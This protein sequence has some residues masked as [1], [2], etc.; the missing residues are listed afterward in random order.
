[1]TATAGVTYTYDGDGKRVKKSSGKLY[2]YGMGSDALLETDASGTVTD[3]D[4]FFNGR[5]IARRKSPSGEINYY[6][7]DHLG[8]SRVVSSATGTILDDSDFYPFGSERSVVSSSG[9][10]YKFTGKERDSES[11]LDFF[12]ARHYASNLAASSS[13]TNSPAVPSTPSAPAI[14]SRLGPSPTPTSPTR[15]P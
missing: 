11:G 8:T 7:A 12:I 3:E 1:M 6:F 10:T 9:N 13:P 5:R 15:N 2:W 14:R 4:V